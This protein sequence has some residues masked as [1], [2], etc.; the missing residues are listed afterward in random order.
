[1]I[2]ADAIRARDRL[3]AVDG[4]YDRATSAVDPCP[5]GLSHP[6]GHR[7]RQHRVGPVGGRHAC[8]VVLGGRPDLTAA[9]G[10]LGAEDS[11]AEETLA[12]G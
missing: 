6:C 8:P 9:G 4:A 1:M 10:G 11:A 12:P 7:V 3:L 5:V 2:R